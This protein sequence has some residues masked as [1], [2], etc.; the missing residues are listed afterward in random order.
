MSRRVEGG[1]G[2]GPDTATDADATLPDLAGRSV[3][4]TG[5]TSGIGREGARRLGRAGARV[6]VHGREAA[7]AL[8]VPCNNAGVY[9][10]RETSAQGYDPVLAVN[11]L[12]PYLLTR[13]LVDHLAAGAR[14]VTTSSAAHRSGT[15]NVDAVRAGRTG[16]SGFDA[17]A[18][19]KLYNVLFTRELARRFDGRTAVCFHPGVIPGSGLARTVPFPFSLGWRALALVPGVGDAVADGGRALATHAARAD[20]DAAGAYFDGTRE[21]R[22]ARAAR[23]D[24]AAE[25]LWTVSADL[26][27]VDPDWP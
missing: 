9:R 16:S 15:L 12:A 17:Y 26:V 11:H 3:L 6:L 18:D 27:G 8:D 20:P 13:D 5:A 23:V 4:V 10:G 21:T 19:S 14:V 25:R 2:D 22:P 24:R 7:D 1:G